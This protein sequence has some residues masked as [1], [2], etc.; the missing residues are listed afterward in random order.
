MDI[1]RQV[2]SFS[3]YLLTQSLTSGGKNYFQEG[4]GND[5]VGKYIPLALREKLLKLQILTLCYT[6]SRLVKNLEVVKG[7]LNRP[8]TLSE[9]V[10]KFIISIS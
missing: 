1:K 5:F 7:R 4:G 9:K 8:L 10:V 2:F 6:L 3:W